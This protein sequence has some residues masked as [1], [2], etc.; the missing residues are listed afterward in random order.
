MFKPRAESNPD[1]MSSNPAHQPLH[2]VAELPNLR[3]ND[4]TNALANQIAGEQS[5]SKVKIF[6][7][8]IPKYAS[9]SVN[10]FSCSDWN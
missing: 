5:K 6:Y 8:T 1:Y 9:E 4:L 7:A 2:H 3:C 10:P